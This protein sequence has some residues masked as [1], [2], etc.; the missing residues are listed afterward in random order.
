[1]GNKYDWKIQRKNEKDEYTYIYN[2]FQ[3][4]K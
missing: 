1:M 2:D 4:Q 3:S